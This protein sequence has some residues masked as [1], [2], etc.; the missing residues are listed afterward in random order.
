L[1]TGKNLNPLVYTFSKL[2]IQT[3]VE[4]EPFYEKNTG[5]FYN[6]IQQEGISLKF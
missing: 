3:T 4:K 2:Y 6:G 5:G 1:V